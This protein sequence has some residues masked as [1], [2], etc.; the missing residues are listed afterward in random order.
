[1]FHCAR[2]WNRLVT[3]KAYVEGMYASLTLCFPVTF[4]V[5]LFATRNILLASYGIL[6]IGCIVMCVL[7]WC[8]LV[9]GWC[10]LSLARAL[11]RRGGT[12]THSTHTHACAR[13]VAREAS[14]LRGLTDAPPAPRRY[15]G[16]AETIAAVMIVGLSVDYVVHLGHMFLESPLG[17]RSREKRVAF[18]SV[19]MGVT[20]VGGAGTTFGAGVIMFA[21][22]ITFFEKF[23]VLIPLT[24]FFSLSYALFFFMPLCAILGPSGKC[25]DVL[26]PLEKLF[27]L[28]LARIKKSEVG[29]GEIS[30]RCCV[31]FLT[32]AA[33]LT[34]DG[35]ET[36]TSALLAA[37][38]GAVREAAAAEHG[39]GIEL[40][41]REG[42]QAPSKET[43]GG[44]SDALLRASGGTRIV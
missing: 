1:M 27:A 12:P 26:F 5:L 22:Q 6:S 18:S 21:C 23:A 42:A 17:S 16:T 7:G 37:G 28:A 31:R 13:T 34:I 4:G 29:A 3:Q 20:V 33:G 44:R 38:D 15:L 41:S 10:V 19:A 30:K 25:G 11:A 8:K 36:Y 24:I 40:A 2:T 9:M 43:A 32:D 35:E 39:A 14:S